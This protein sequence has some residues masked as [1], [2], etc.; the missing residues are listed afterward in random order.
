M[1]RSPKKIFKKAPNYKNPGSSETPFQIVEH[2]FLWWR[3]KYHRFCAICLICRG[4]KHT[5]D[6]MCIVIHFYQFN[7]H[8]FSSIAYYEYT[9]F[10]R[11]LLS[12][13]NSLM[14]N[15]YPIC[16]NSTVV[17]SEKCQTICLH[18]RYFWSGVF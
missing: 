17:M 6:S 18:T 4:W 5:F 13:F 3:H 14:H 15:V 12:K 2:A 11:Y 16:K 8:Q 7:H 9:C 1:C 10:I